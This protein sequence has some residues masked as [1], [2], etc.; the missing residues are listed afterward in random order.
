MKT[1]SPVSLTTNRI[2]PRRIPPGQT[3]ADKFPVLTY[4][5]VPKVETGDW[6][7][8]VWG[9]VEEPV[10]FTW[11]EFM[12]LPQTSLKADFHCVTA[13]SRAATPRIFL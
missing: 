9:P 8:D 13:W 3:P 5:D 6:K 7:L 12:K 4:G 10:S 1:G 11:N 2:D